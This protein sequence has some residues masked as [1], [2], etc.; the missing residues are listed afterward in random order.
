MWKYIIKYLLSKKRNFRA[1][2][3]I[4]MLRLFIKDLSFLLQHFRELF[5][6]CYAIENSIVY[7]EKKMIY[8]VFVYSVNQKFNQMVRC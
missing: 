7:N 8:I 4:L 6:A 5:S 2:S 3:E 1:N